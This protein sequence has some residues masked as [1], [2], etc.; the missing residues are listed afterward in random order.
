[1]SHQIR[2]KKLEVRGLGSGAALPEGCGATHPLSADLKNHS[3]AAVRGLGRKSGALSYTPKLFTLFKVRP[4]L[5]D[6]FADVA[7]AQVGVVASITQHTERRVHVPRGQ[8]RMAG[9]RL[10][11]HGCSKGGRVGCT[12]LDSSRGAVKNESNHDFQGIW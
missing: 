2:D 6:A 7:A 10:T 11:R 5:G 4:C 3:G 12:V 8:G 9:W 1:M